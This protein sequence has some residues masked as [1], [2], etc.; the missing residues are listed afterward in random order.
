MNRSGNIGAAKNMDTVFANFT[1]EELEQDLI[2]DEDDQLVEIV[3]GYT[4]EG[5]TI[6]EED[7]EIMKIT[8]QIMNDDNTGDTPA[9]VKKDTETIL[10]PDNKTDE[11]IKDIEAVDDK[12]LDDSQTM[13]SLK[14]NGESEADKE[15]GLDKLEDEYHSS[16]TVEE[17]YKTWFENNGDLGDENKAE[18]T[19]TS[20][21]NKIDNTKIEDD[22]KNKE[23][24]NYQQTADASVKENAGDLGDENKAEGTDTSFGNKELDNTMPKDDIKPDEDANHNATNDASIK[25]ASEEGVEKKCDCG[26]EDCPIC[27]P[28]AGDLAPDSAPVADIAADGERHEES[29]GETITDANGEGIA[30]GKVDDNTLPKEDEMTP[31][32]S[33]KA[34]NG[35]ITDDG[36]KECENKESAPE[37]TVEPEIKK[38]DDATA[39]ISDETE[40][41]KV[42]EACCG[43]GSD[44]PSEDSEVHVADTAT[45][46]ADEAC[47][48]GSCA[49]KDCGGAAGIG[50]DNNVP[51][52]GFDEAT[53]LEDANLGVYSIT[54]AKFNF[55]PK[56]KERKELKKAW[57]AAKEGEDLL[58]NNGMNSGAGAVKGLKIALRILDIFANIDSVIT[59]PLCFLVVGLPLHLIYRGIS[60]A[61]NAGQEAAAQ[62]YCMKVVEK[63]EKI[64]EKTEKEEDK[65]KIQKKI[66]TIKEKLNKMKGVEESSNDIIANLQKQ[67]AELQESVKKLQEAD[68]V[69]KLDDVAK[70]A[71]DNNTSTTPET[72]DNNGDDTEVK[73]AGEVEVPCPE[74]EKKIIEPVANKGDEVEVPETQIDGKTPAEV[75][76]NE[77]KDLE[78]AF[79]TLLNE[80]D[81]FTEEVSKA[82]VNDAAKTEVED[83]TTE[84]DDAL[85]AV[86]DEPEGSADID[87]EY[88]PTDEELID[89]IDEC[90]A[91]W[92]KKE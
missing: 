69:I 70:N 58:N 90:F 61:L 86:A 23:D 17:A 6:F 41:G 62:S 60:L 47:G 42:D 11:N 91:E 81:D 52:A 73:E 54:E 2:F 80:E 89:D 85:A 53:L 44:V 28:K 21:G 82:D 64:K 63:L 68:E 48:K 27:N 24:E 39:P 34:D 50:L 84:L 40:K 26:K 7:Q 49:T 55:F 77:L 31:D 43:K 76:Q 20:F 3:E 13:D 22:L 57:D 16:A 46:P 10:G 75:E 74:A 32:C 19:D 9:E 5:N 8:D 30:P 78:E 18:G 72:G 79:N 38:E 14:K 88:D 1:D 4:E 67:I 33:P 36:C 59:T 45:K 29:N 25:E 37:G 12:K 66:D 83:T 15:L 65:E 35:D 87:Y 51:V 56:F 71:E 92:L